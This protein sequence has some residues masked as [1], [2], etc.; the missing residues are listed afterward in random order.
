MKGLFRSLICLVN[1]TEQQNQHSNL[2]IMTADDE[3][4]SS[5]AALAA[6]FI[7]IALSL[8]CSPSSDSINPLTFFSTSSAL[9]CPSSESSIDRASFISSTN[10]T[11]FSLCSAYNG[12]ATIGTPAHTASSVEFHPQKPSGSKES[13]SGSLCALM[14]TLRSLVGGLRTTHKNLWP[15]FSSPAAI[16]L[17]CSSVSSPRLPK[18]RNTTL[19]LGWESSQVTHS[20]GTAS[21]E[22]LLLP[23]PSLCPSARINGPT[24]KSG[25]VRLSGAQSPSDIVLIT[26]DSKRSK[27]SSSRSRNG[28]TMSVPRIGGR[29]GI[30][31]KSF[32]SLKLLRESRSGKEVYNNPRNGIV[33]GDGEE[34]FMHKRFA[35]TEDLEN[36]GL[37]VGGGGGREGDSGKVVEFD[38]REGARDGGYVGIQFASTVWFSGQ[39]YVNGEGGSVAEQVFA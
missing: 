26:L 21:S 22:L 36:E 27:A 2:M 13:R 33:S 23:P 5:I 31:G 24:Q 29:P 9:T 30:S 38:G 12:H 18:Q 6:S 11:L 7:A 4:P 37:V 39:E 25:G 3:P 32:T 14:A 8:I 1:P 20:S 34:L 19:W 35:Q 16:S 28:L 17:N 15:L 10:T